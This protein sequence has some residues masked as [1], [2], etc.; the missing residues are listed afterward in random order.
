MNNIYT[1]PILKYPLTDKEYDRIDDVWRFLLYFEN[2]DI[3]NSDFRVR[4][5]SAIKNQ[6]T[7]DEFYN[8]E[9]ILRKLFWNL[10]WAIFLLWVKPDL[11]EDEYYKLIK[12]D[13]GN[14]KEIPNSLLLCETHSYKDESDLQNK[15]QKSD[16]F[17]KTYYRSF[18][19]KIVIIDKQNNK[20]IMKP[21]EGSSHIFKKNYFN[22]LTI[23][24]LFDKA[25]YKE[26]MNNPYII[27]FKKI[28]TAPYYHQQDY[29]FPN[30]NF[31]TFEFG[32]KEDMIN[33]IKKMYYYKNDKYWFKLL[34]PKN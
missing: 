19:N 14:Y 31:C 23:T 11:S 25:L 18:I 4:T 3:F 1:D 28:K 24:I 13:Y 16:F 5:I 21:I 34:L 12:N 8:Y 2:N 32:T 22:L 15:L 26:V 30:L 7:I 29:G 10:R 33:R 9:T 17:D 20:I 6:Y 27:K